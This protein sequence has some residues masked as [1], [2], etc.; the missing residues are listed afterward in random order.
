MDNMVDEIQTNMWNID[1]IVV[2]NEGR[3]SFEHYIPT[4][5]SLS[6]HPIYSVTKS[7]MS[8][9]IGIA[10]QEGFLGSLDA[11]VLDFFPDYI[12][13]E[14]S[15]RKQNM[16][17]E[18]LLTMSAGLS[19]NEL[20]IPYSDPAN[21][22]R[23]YRNSPDPVQYML[24]L[25]MSSPPGL[26]FNYNSGV[27]HL[28]AVILSRIT[29]MTPRA[30]A[31]EYLFEPLGISTSVW[32]TDPSGIHHGGHGLVLNVHDL[33]RFGYLFLND[34]YWDDKQILPEGWVDDA[35]QSYVSVDGSMKYGY[36]WWV[37][38]ELGA[39]VAQGYL[40]QNIWVFPK[41]DM[42]V[43]FTSTL[44]ELQWPFPY[45]AEK[46]LTDGLGIESSGLDPLLLGVIG[47]VSIGIVVMV[48]LYRRWFRV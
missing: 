32:T 40:G 14:M 35:S 10:L 2:V 7:V 42:V 19:W 5:N 3:I 29:E 45:L 43:V 31:E 8:T 1:S 30:F 39:F 20:T 25:P 36:Q 17:V 27:S 48:L 24:D 47:G 38:P 6:G 41:H 44:A 15:D 11:K 13:E 34:G 21:D 33:A 22:F 46:Y 12:F 18:H 16:T 37:Y 28:L 4:Y 23:G 26:F 9:L